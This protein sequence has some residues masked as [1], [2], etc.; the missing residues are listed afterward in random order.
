MVLSSCLAAARRPE[1][2]GKKCRSSEG[3]GGFQVIN[4]IGVVLGKEETLLNGAY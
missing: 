3:E 4:H 1:R 2:G